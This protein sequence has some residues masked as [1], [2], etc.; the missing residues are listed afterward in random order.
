MKQHCWHATGHGFN[1][2]EKGGTIEIQ[3]CHCAVTAR[4]NFGFKLR[5]IPGH[6]PHHPDSKVKVWYPVTTD[7]V[8]IERTSQA[9][10]HP[11]P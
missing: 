2:D 10:T 1:R 8:C 7:N 3:C 11:E 6:G 5:V 4:Q 9:L